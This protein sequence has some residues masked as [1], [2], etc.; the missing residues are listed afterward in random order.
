[1]SMTFCKFSRN[2]GVSSSC[3]AAVWLSESCFS[4]PL[5]FWQIAFAFSFST[6][7]N[8]FALCWWDDLVFD[9]TDGKF[10]RWFVTK[11]FKWGVK[12]GA[13]VSWFWAPL[14]HFLVIL[15]KGGEATP[16]YSCLF[17]FL[18][19][20]KIYAVC[21]IRAIFV[22]AVRLEW[23]SWLRTVNAVCVWTKIE[24][25][26][27]FFWLSFLVPWYPIR[28]SFKDILLMLLSR[29]TKYLTQSSINATI[30][31]SSQYAEGCGLPIGC[32]EI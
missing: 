11:M 9:F 27:F 15:L 24:V 8:I 18:H 19:A 31:C 13:E 20:I 22:L 7:R 16:C 30:K 29:N 4:S 26:K 1:M 32:R 5:I 12:M 10:G 25:A 14:W 28:F 17:I 21:R 3:V 23:N 2:S 6:L